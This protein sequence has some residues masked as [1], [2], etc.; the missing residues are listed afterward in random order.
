MFSTLRKIADDKDGEW[1]EYTDSALFAINTN[2]SNTT[3][4]TPFYVMYG[5]HARLPLEVQ[6][7]VEQVD[8]DPC[9][10][11]KLA[12]E[13]TSE[14]VL[15]EHVEK[16]TSTRDALFP[17]VLGNIEAAQE[18]Q[19][20]EYLKRRGFDCTFKNGDAVLCR[21]MLQKTFQRHLKPSRVTLFSRFS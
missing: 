16:I 11:E 1:D 10:I 9:K 15:Q 18:K 2:R 5:R 8:Q 12:S 21:N 4:Y 17:K 6:K 20:Q 14:D 3:K 13:L 7:Y 19:K